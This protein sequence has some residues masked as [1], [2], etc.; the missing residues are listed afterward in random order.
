MLALGVRVSKDCDAVVLFRVARYTDLRGNALGVTGALAWRLPPSK[1]ARLAGERSDVW[2]GCER[3]THQNI[4][5][6]NI[7][8]ADTRLKNYYFAY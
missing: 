3:A 2:G 4:T 6:N 7:A 5:Q 8:A 1:L